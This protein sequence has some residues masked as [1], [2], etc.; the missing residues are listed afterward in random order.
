MLLIPIFDVAN[1]TITSISM[2]ICCYRQQNM[3]SAG[4]SVAMFEWLLCITS[5]NGDLSLGT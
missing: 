5:L 1:V 3:S 2:A 4:C